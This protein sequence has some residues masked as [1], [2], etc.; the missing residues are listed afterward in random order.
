MASPFADIQRKASG[1]VTNSVEFARIVRLPRRVL[2]LEKVYG[3]D[4]CASV[5]K[6]FAKQRSTMRFWPIQAAA[7]VEAA[8]ADGLF[9]AIGVGWGKCESGATEVYTNR[10]R[11]RVDEIVA[12]KFEV[13]AFGSN[14]MGWHEATAARSGTKRC[15]DLVL[16]DGSKL[17]ASTDHPIMTQRGWVRLDELD[18]EN[19]L[20]A[21]ARSAPAPKKPY[22]IEDDAVAL[23][24]FLLADGSYSQTNSTPFFCDDNPKVLAE[25]TRLGHKYGGGITPQKTHSKASGFYMPGLRPFLKNYGLTSNLSRNKRLPPQF[26]CLPDDQVALFLNRFCACDGHVGKDKIEITLASEGLI[27]DI[28]FLLSRLGVQGRSRYKEARCEGKTFDAWRLVISGADAAEFLRIVGPVL[29]SEDRS[30]ALADKLASTLRNTNCDVVPIDCKQ[31]MSIVEEMGTRMVGRKTEVREFCGATDGQRLSREKFA[32]FCDKYNYTGKHAWLAAADIRW[33]KIKSIESGLDLPVYDLSVPSVENF[34]ANGILVHNTLI[35]LA[36]PTAMN[37]KNAVILVPPRL[38]KKTL[39]EVRDVYGRQFHLDLANIRVVSYTQLSSARQATILD[40]IKPDLIIADECHSLSHRSSARTKRFLRYMK[41]H[42]E[43]RFVAL[44]GTVTRKSIIDY[45]HLIELALR[46]NSPLPFGYREVKDWA[47][48]LDVDPEYLMAP[49]VLIRFCEDG[50]DVRSGF[51][52]RLVETPGVVA[53]RESD[54]GVGLI[55][56]KLK[57]AVPDG[58]IQVMQQVRKTWALEDEEF[59]S[60]LA[61][62]RALRQISTGHFLRWDWPGGKPDIKWLEARKEWHRDVRDILKTSKKGLDSPFLIA[63]AAA[64]GRIAIPSWDKW[65]AFKDRKPPPTVAVWLDDF[66]VDA[67]IHW[68]KVSSK[69]GNCII[70]YEHAAL[71]KRIAEKSRFP[72]Y[73]A[74]TDADTSKERVIVCSVKS[75][76]TGKNLQHFSRNL[77][78]TL[79]PSGMAFEQVIGRTHRPGQKEDDVFADWYAHTSILEYAMETVLADAHY[80]QDTM[81]GR[82]KVLLATRI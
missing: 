21:T 12:D 37:S 32:A 42:P 1:I 9:A 78:T 72:L 61:V 35:S 43:C 24:A 5:T 17:Q 73:G 54:L 39:R 79:P 65:K 40:T 8:N 67:A 53:T 50:E 71:G 49:G 10:G 62:T 60:A 46:K 59:D 47:G 14:K 48:A 26:Y 81:G 33:E 75:Q 80:I 31:L 55:I 23:G 70:W 77:F 25:V 64:A 76:G 7:L 22:V 28:K 27:R 52:R 82:Q 15:Y 44:S 57:P 2:D 38:K 56:R 3:P 16:V 58:I 20:V 41:E 29:G 66:I 13:S 36:M 30:V 18:Q 19:D 74:G 11:F 63:M 51:R 6:I 4:L 68:A 45:A 34:A 69:E